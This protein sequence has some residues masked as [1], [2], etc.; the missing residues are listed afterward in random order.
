MSSL[1]E[2]I[3]IHYHVTASIRNNS[4]FLPQDFGK[5]VYEISK[6]FQVVYLITFV[7]NDKKNN[8]RIPLKNIKI[9]NLGKKLHPIKTFLKLNSYKS[10]I[11]KHKSKFEVICFRVPSFLAIY[12][13]ALLINKRK[14]FYIVGSMK[15]AKTF[16]VEFIPKLKNLLYRLYWSI[17]SYILNIFYKGSLVLTNNSGL[18]KTKSGLKKNDIIFTSTIEKKDILKKKKYS[19]NNKLNIIYIGR[20][21]PEK[22]IQ[23]LIKAISKIK[24]RIDNVCLTI[25]GSGDRHYYKSLKAMVPKNEI[26]NFKFINHISS[27]IKLKNK[28]DSSDIFVMPSIQDSQ[29]RVIWEAMARGL[30]IICS[31]GVNSIYNDFR[32]NKYIK[33]FKV[34]RSNKLAQIIINMYLNKKLLKD[35][36]KESIKIAKTKT[37]NVSVALFYKRVRDFYGIGID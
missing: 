21:S 27:Q 25:I 1:N 33:F 36:S 30:P 4:L 18:L 11:Y 19:S 24:K 3:A 15:G 6:K 14:V 34:G 8:F 31:N 28:I 13:S 26:K 29:P 35:M 5:W 9:I 12:L 32:N 22:D 2:T 23:T 17:D 37:N 7:D 16:K 10:E 20:I